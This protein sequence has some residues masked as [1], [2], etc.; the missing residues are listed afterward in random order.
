MKY[1]VEYTKGAIFSSEC[2]NIETVGKVIEWI[3][4]KYQHCNFSI[5]EIHPIIVGEKK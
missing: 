4:N 5:T 2:E 3:M 1:R